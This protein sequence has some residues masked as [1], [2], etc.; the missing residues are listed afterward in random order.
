MTTDVLT[1]KAAIAKR[2]IACIQENYDEAFK[3][4]KLL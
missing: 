4:L 1:N 3:T 2:C